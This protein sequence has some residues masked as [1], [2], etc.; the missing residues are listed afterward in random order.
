MNTG[1][2]ISRLPLFGTPMC[3]YCGGVANTSDHTPPLCLL[4][5]SLPKNFQAM[6][7]PA[8]TACNT[9]YSKD[10]E[11][12]EAIICIVSFTNADREAVAEG[13]RLYLKMQRHHALRDFID[14]RLGSDGNF[15]RDQ[16]VIETV[17]RVMKKT[18][19]GLLFF[20]FGRLVHPDDLSVIALEHAKNVHPA[21][22]AELHRRND[23][24]WAKVTPSG[25][26]LERQVFALEGIVPPHMPEWQVYIPEFFEY[27]FVRRSNRMLMCAVKLHDA[28]TVLLECPWPS[29]AGPR[30]NGKAQ[31]WRVRASAHGQRDL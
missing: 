2:W 19:T 10:E 29:R 9:G 6:T 5:R 8:C 12:T 7:V 1:K 3:V 18:A 21:A 20:E 24:L 22:F 14:E 25:R 11:L 16:A 13:G 27:V 17:S 15:Y 26:E 28:L 30:R 31:T 23:S 4:P